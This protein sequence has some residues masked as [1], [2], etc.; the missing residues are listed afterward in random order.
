[1]PFSDHTPH[2][3]K[4]IAELSDEF[5]YYISQLMLHVYNGIIDNIGISSSSLLKAKKK[6]TKLTKSKIKGL[7]KKIKG[8]IG[9]TLPSIKSKF[10]PKKIKL[11]QEKFKK[12][13]VPDKATFDEFKNQVSD[14]M[15]PYL[16]GLSEEMAVKGV[17]LSMVSL[18]EE[19]QGKTIKSYGS[20]RGYLDIEQD[21]FSGAIPDTIRSA[22]ERYNLSDNIQQAINHSHSRTADYIT[23]MKGQLLTS[24]REQITTAARQNKSPQKLASDLYWMKRDK[25]ELKQYTAEMNMR[26]WRRVANTELAHIHETGKLAAMEDEAE[27]SIDGTAKPIYMHFNGSGRCDWCKSKLGTIVRLVPASLSGGNT[28]SLKSMGIDDPFTDIGIWPGKN[29]F[30]RK[31]SEWWIC[32]PAHPNCPDSFSKIDPESQEYDRKQKRLKYKHGKEFEDKYIPKWFLDRL[33]T[34]QAILDQREDRMAKDR[35]KGI[36]RRLSWY[37]EQERKEGVA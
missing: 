37:I 21:Y 22:Q 11:Y 16:D 27:K 33:D 9:R 15:Q 34:T 17:L 13:Y 25:P 14:Y 28:D 8:F 35:A 36:H 6:S 4:Y 24:V 29:N 19:N 1:M 3:L 5:T 30:N 7:S 31:K 20:K 23:E 2:D 10:W 18:Q 32:T 26:N 12:Y